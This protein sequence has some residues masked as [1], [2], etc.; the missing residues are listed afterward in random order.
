MSGMEEVGNPSTVEEKKKC[1]QTAEQR[2][3]QVDRSDTS[4][5]LVKDS[6]YGSLGHSASSSMMSRTVSAL[7]PSMT[8]WTPLPKKGWDFNVVH[9]PK[10]IAM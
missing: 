7:N 4:S 9:H 1:D 6:A 10:R 5:F 3:E 8:S 2:A